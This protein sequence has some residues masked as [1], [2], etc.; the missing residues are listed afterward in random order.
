MYRQTLYTVLQ[1]I[2]KIKE[3]VNVQ[4]VIIIGCS[5]SGKSTFGR[6]LSKVS[7]LPLYHLD[8]MFWNEDKT[9]VERSIFLDRL[10]AVMVKSEWVID[11][12]YGSTMEE[13]IKACDTV[14]FLDYE[15]KVCLDG[16]ESRKG[17][18]RSDMPWINDDNTDEEFILFIK[19]FNFESRP[20]IM[21]L[22][23][24]YSFKNIIVF[25]S[26]EESEEFLLHFKTEE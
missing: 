11:G 18:K 14:F 19:N 26:R 15:T 6:A 10:N 16:I 12:N 24:K 1:K 3:V 17:K 21:D 22:L 7:G 5:G 13:R 23:D 2:K 8:M 25:H 20:K 9:T 4:K